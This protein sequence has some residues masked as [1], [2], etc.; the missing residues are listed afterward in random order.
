MHEML[1]FDSNFDYTLILKQMAHHE[2]GSGRFG[3]DVFRVA[4]VQK[5]ALIDHYAS[6]LSSN[7][8]DAGSF[9]PL[10][11]T[12]LDVV[13]LLPLRHLL[14]CLHGGVDVCFMR[15]PYGSGSGYVNA[16]LILLRPTVEARLFLREWLAAV[17]AEPTVSGPTDQLWANK[18]L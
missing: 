4:S 6:L 9:P 3:D 13:P 7:S 14:Q 2:N 18:L 12:D 5:V 1:A 8:T 10:L 17:K 16:G 15:E 11:F